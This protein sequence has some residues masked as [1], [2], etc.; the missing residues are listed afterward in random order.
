M[1]S[2][3][4]MRPLVNSPVRHH[5]RTAYRTAA[6]L[7]GHPAHRPV[8][9]PL[10]DGRLYGVHLPDTQLQRFYPLFLRGDH[11]KT[12]LDGAPGLQY[13]LCRPGTGRHCIGGKG[14]RHACRRRC[15]EKRAAFPCGCGCGSGI[16]PVVR[17]HHEKREQLYPEVR[18]TSHKGREGVRPGRQLL[19]LCRHCRRTGLSGERDRTVDAH[20]RGHRLDSEKGREDPA[21]RHLASVPLPANEGGTSLFLPV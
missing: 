10:P 1:C 4:F 16:V 2:F 9:L 20:H 6:M 19:L 15:P 14:E 18:A 7:Q 12:G 13:R 11:R 21:G 8:C 3:L 5:R 17:A